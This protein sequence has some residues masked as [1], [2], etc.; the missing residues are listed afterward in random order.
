MEWIGAVMVALLGACVGLLVGLFLQ[1]ARRNQLVEQANEQQAMA[2]AEANELHATTRALAEESGQRHG[3]T[4]LLLEKQHAELRSQLLAMTAALAERMQIV[5]SSLAERTQIVGG[6]L[7]AELRESNAEHRN[8]LRLALGLPRTSAPDEEP[9][10][11]FAPVEP[12]PK[13]TPQP[14]TSSRLK[15]RSTIPPPRPAPL[16][17]PAPP[18]RPTITT[19]PIAS[20]SSRPTPTSG[21]VQVPRAILP[22]SPSDEP[23][24]PSGWTLEEVRSH[25]AAAD[26]GCRS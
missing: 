18:P 6:A 21:R 20:P 10:A 9:P 4:L 23:T 25:S 8:D 26:E 22:A 15:A 13:L 3:A 7:A 12:R 19:A 11:T 16:P 14:V 17:K 24:P 1:G 2:H 5:G